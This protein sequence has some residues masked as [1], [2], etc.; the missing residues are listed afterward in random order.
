MIK[1][2]N[3]MSI[4]LVA[5]L[6]LLF[7]ATAVLARGPMNYNP[8]FHKT[9]QDKVTR[10]LSNVGNWAYWIAWDGLSAH[11]PILDDSGG[12]YPRQTTHVI[13]TDG[14]VWGAY[15]GGINPSDL[16]ENLHVGGVTYAV[17]TVPGYID[18]GGNLVGQ[19]NER[20]RM[21]RIRKKYTKYWDQMT[22]DEK[23]AAKADLA[24]DAAE[25]NAVDPGSVTEAM[26][27]EIVDHYAW[28][29]ENWPADLGAPTYPDGTPGLADADQV[30]WFVANDFDNASA[31]AL[32]GTGTIG[33]EIQTTMWAY[34]QP[35]ATLGQVIFKKYQIINK[36]GA[37][38]D[39]MFLAQWSDPDV[40][41]YT[42]DLTGCDVDLSLMFGY[43]GYQKDDQYA[44]F[45]LPPAA[46]GY[47]FFQ[48]PLV[49]GKAGEDLNMNGI[50]DAEDFAVFDLQKVGPGYINLP[51]TS[52]GYFSAGAPISDPPL[53]D[54]VAT[55]EWYNML[56]G[57]TPTDNMTSPTPYIAGAGP[58]AGQPTKFPLSG[59]PVL[60]T[61]DIDGFGANFPPGDR[62][63]FMCSGPFTMAPGDTQ[64]LVVAVVGGIVPTEAGDNRNA[65]AQLK[66]N[67][68]LAQFLY[69]T[70]FIGIPTPPSPA[71]LVKVTE[72]E[73]QI[74]LNWGT[75]PEMYNETEKDDPVLGFN[76]EGYNVYQ[77]PNARATKDQA[78][79]VAT[80]DKKNGVLVITG[81]KFLPEFGAEVEV[82]I[83][84]GTDSGIQRYFVIEKDYIN[85]APLYPGTKYYFAVTAYNYNKDPLAPEPS[86]ETALN[87]LEVIPQPP[88]PGRRFE[89]TPKSM[90]D[91]AHI[92]GASDG[93]VQAMVVDPGALTG[94]T[95]EI[96]FTEDTDTNSA[97]YGELLWNV[98]NSAG[99]VLV[100]NQ[101][102]TATL[103]ER[104]DQPIFDGIQVKVTG[105]ALDFKDFQVVANASGPLAEPVG[106]AADY[107]GFP[108]LGRT[109]IINQQ[110]NGS[111]WFI[112]SIRNE[113][114]SY[115]D[116]V[117]AVTQY[118]GGFGE[119]VTGLAFLIPRDY[120][121][122]F[123]GQGRALFRWP[124]Y[125]TSH[126]DVFMGDVPFELWCIGDVNDPNDDFQCL[127]WIFDWDADGVF[128]LVDTTDHAGSGADNDPFTD[129]IYWLEPL[130]RDQAGYEALLAL[131]ESNPADASAAV[132]W[133]YLTTSYG[134]FDWNCVAGLMR[135]S[136]V[137]WN[138]GDVHDPDWPNNVNAPMPEQGTIFRIITAKPNSEQDVFSFKAPSYQEYAAADAKADAEKVNVFPNPYY[139][140]NP[141]ETGRF[142]RFVT[143]NHLPAKAT[144]RIF[145]LAG[146]MVR[147]LEKDP[148][149]NPGQFFTWDL[150]NEAGLPI[151]SGIYIAHI[152]MPDLGA[153]KVLKIFIVQSAQILEYY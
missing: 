130:S 58:T 85:D 29:W 135:M 39:S 121:I 17:G 108:G 16:K 102:Q 43:S 32:Y 50:D 95:Y 7:F 23:D 66:I 86:L 78:R 127:P 20:V 133:A 57:Y 92:Q 113:E 124:Y 153:T 51:M 111:R 125:S 151:A 100:A 52:Y 114:N 36:S 53:G 96:F 104:D 115:E 28:S 11:D 26:V 9:V 64:E 14:V 134:G 101:Q 22:A 45:N 145:N 119:A 80:F 118:S 21:Y 137:N 47:D 35:A 31:V 72:M 132:L 99:D 93:Q 24:K 63:M 110:T 149:T 69:S 94:D 144:I 76:F 131:H 128:D 33:I 67:D 109:G 59:D 123:T 55:Y 89:S 40:G 8:A 19:D 10:T 70:L 112:Y 62:R 49:K 42:D 3:K 2:R 61:G 81:K 106:A 25:H 126:D 88:K 68:R 65:V 79:V 5:G 148:N 18:A 147:K 38:L 12:I 87:L 84:R 37:T 122:R 60:L 146:S 141:Q 30:I 71:P 138:G 103:D 41:T 105:P 120:E 75:N 1:K 82:P 15:K 13:F 90:L 74:V 56:N 27:K 136:L 73:D 46:V 139:A 54:I 117:D 91:V 142:D 129:G 77:L 143:F 4:P 44:A 48:G 152:D 97:T 140:F 150:K 83:Q 98:R 6:L 107:N 34:D 116:F